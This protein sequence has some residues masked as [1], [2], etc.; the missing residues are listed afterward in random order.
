MKKYYL[1]LAV[2]FLLTVIFFW[3][4][5]FLGEVFYFGDNF[6][7]FIPN[8][9]FWVEN[10]RKGIFPLWNPLTFSGVPYA[11]DISVFP[12]YLGNM[13]WLIFKPLI[14]LTSLA[15]VEIFLM[16]FFCWLYLGKI[17]FDK[18][19]RILGAVLVMFSGSV[20]TH[21]GNISILNVI[22]WLPLVLYFLERSFESNKLRDVLLTSLFLSIS[23]LG[24]HL[25][26]F[27]LNGL[28]LG[29]YFIFKIRGD[30]KE[31]IVKGGLVV[32]FF[33]GMSAF[34]I[35]PLMEYVGLTTRPVNDFEYASSG[36]LSPVVF[37]RLIL[38]EFY[39]R[40][41][42]GYSW[43]PGALIERGYADVTGYV[44]VVSLLLF[45]FAVIKK[46]EK[47]KFWIISGVSFL[48]LSFGKYSPFYYLFYKVVPL[49]SRFRNPS[50]FLFLYSFCVIVVSLYVVKS[51]L[52]KG[53]KIKNVVRMEFVLRVG[54]VVSGLLLFV[55]RLFLGK[56]V[57]LLA[58]WVG[59]FIGANISMPSYYSLEKVV[60]ILELIVSNL[61]VFAFI[62]IC[63]FY[64][65]ILMRKRQISKDVFKLLVISLVFF[66]LFLFSRNSLY[67]AK[68]NK[69]DVPEEAVE[70]LESKMEIGER[71]LS[72]SQIVPYS[73]LF[74]YWNQSMVR[75]PFGQSRVDEKEIDSFRVFKK[76]ASLLPPNLGMNYDLATI[77]GY[78]GTVLNSY[79]EYFD[80]KGESKNINNVEISDFGDEG[81]DKLG[82]R[83][84]VGDEGVLLYDGEIE[85]KGYELVF[86]GSFVKIYENRQRWPR[87]YIIT[88]SQ[89]EEREIKEY[90]SNRV[91]V[92]LE[93]GDKGKVV[94]TDSYYPGWQVEREGRSLKIEKYDGALRLVEVS[95]GK[96]E[97]V[98]SYQP[99]GFYL[100]LL[101]SLGFY[102]VWPLQRVLS[103]VRK[104]KKK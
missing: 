2:F 10:I 99:K 6:N 79:A 60:V 104:M 47:T 12:F 92:G 64:L 18:Y 57:G 78:G 73:G 69:L 45:I 53:E 90:G 29:L 4:N 13:F 51:I 26:F 14:A 103:Y 3:K 55:N 1:P 68:I 43:G 8:K 5:V 76:E 22:I 67:S 48:V 61:L 82:V 25:Q 94:L 89:I 35:I 59:N 41:V 88:N 97:L 80:K 38:A 36:S 21:I 39:G 70:Y 40:L 24:G 31:K 54:L 83:Y 77:N 100:G 96:G 85:E 65:V 32:L 84:L 52:D 33:V 17:G 74:N 34:Q 91:V 44:G 98:F 42:D 11:G 16:G 81:V 9:I 20:V 37:P 46:V 87:A 23:F 95:G 7:F 28:F 19:L 49:F 75:E 66:D 58:G 62:V 15:V 27:Y 93:D 50:Q 71:Y 101:I 102:L 56:V 30:I 63:F 72:S 86:D